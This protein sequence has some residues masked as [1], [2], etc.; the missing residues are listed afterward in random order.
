[1]IASEFSFTL[2]CGLA[3]LDCP[4]V[5]KLTR[6][7]HHRRARSLV[8]AR[9]AESCAP[10]RDEHETLY[11]VSIGVLLRK[12]CVP[13][14]TKTMPRH[15]R[16]RGTRGRA[17]TMRRKPS[18]RKPPTPPSRAAARTRAP[19]A[20]PPR[21]RPQP[22]SPRQR[23]RCKAPYKAPISHL[24]EPVMP[25]IAVCPNFGSRASPML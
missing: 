22:H 10:F 5:Q 9:G 8:H 21:R 3:K 19:S 14:V 20:V 12:L 18:P 16:A 11:G 7:T 23:P 15:S 17:Q 2:L 13:R 6:G 4:D 25:K 1:M 24:T